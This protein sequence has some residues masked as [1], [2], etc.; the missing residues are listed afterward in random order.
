[1]EVHNNANSILLHSIDDK[2]VI[3]SQINEDETDEEVQ[4]ITEHMMVIPM[5]I[6]GSPKNVNVLVHSHEKPGEHD[7]GNT[8]RIHVFRLRSID[9]CYIWSKDNVMISVGYSFRMI[10]TFV[11]E[12]HL[13]TNWVKSKIE[14]SQAFGEIKL[15]CLNIIKPNHK[16]RVSVRI[17]NCTNKDIKINSGEYIADL[18]FYPIKYYMDNM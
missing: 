3:D 9:Q 17:F 7:I 5:G 10:N 2:A 14:E 1:M 11:G 12:Y 15:G 16:G 8:N 13:N 6:A 4:G 18:I